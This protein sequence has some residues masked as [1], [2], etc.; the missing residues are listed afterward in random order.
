M[1]SFKHAFASTAIA[2]LC[3]AAGAQSIALVSSEKDNALAIVNLKDQ[4]VEGT[5]P[6]C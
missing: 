3:S 2:A 1:I 5:I 6:T 4:K